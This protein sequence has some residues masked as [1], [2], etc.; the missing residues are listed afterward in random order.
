LRHQK[1]L[2]ARRL[3]IERDRGIA[4]VAVLCVLSLLTVLA[5]G[6]LEGTRRHG[7]L[8]HRSF[9]SAQASELAD[10]AIR[11]AILE[12]TAPAELA[13]AMRM[14]S[15]KTVRVFDEDVEVRI[16]REMMRAD[17]NAASEET[18]ASALSEQGLRESEARSLAAR[19]V[20]WRDVDDEPSAE[21]AERTEYRRAGRDNG[22]RNGPFETVSELRQVLGGERLTDAMLDAFTIYS[23]AKMPDNNASATAEVGALAGEVVRVSACATALRTEACRVAIVRLTG[24]RTQPVLVYSWKAQRGRVGQP[25]T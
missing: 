13:A 17:L 2:K 20:D 8:A 25:N 7:Q 9:E 4:L 19:I 3:H 22:P 16:E 12:M 6:A 10:S 5:I 1:V 21:G 23:H 11:V 15:L 18:L 24:K 14:Q